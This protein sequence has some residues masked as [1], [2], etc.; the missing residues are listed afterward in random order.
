[1]NIHPSL[2][3]SF[4]GHG[5]Y[6][7][8]VHEEVLKRG[9][10]I[11]GCT[12]H[13]VDDKYDHGP[14]VVQKSVNVLSE[15]TSSSLAARVFQAECEAYPEAIDLFLQ[16][17]LKVKENCVFVLGQQHIENTQNSNQD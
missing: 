2:L 14:I 17:R 8:R 15:D 3:P 12:V 7:S 4:G 10:K 1:M 11:T 6:G 9:C 16:N 13:F 5:Y